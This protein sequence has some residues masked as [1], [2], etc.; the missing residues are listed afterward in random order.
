MAGLAHCH[1]Q[2]CCLRLGLRPLPLCRPAF[3]VPDLSLE[4]VM[5]QRL[6]PDAAAGLAAAGAVA[7]GLRG[8]VWPPGG[9]SP[10]R[11]VPLSVGHHQ[12]QSGPMASECCHQMTYP[13]HCLP[14]RPHPGRAEM[15]APLGGSCH[16][17]CR[18]WLPYLLA[19]A[20]LSVPKNHSP[21]DQNRPTRSKV[22]S[23]S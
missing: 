9:A 16:K 20:M 23:H 22:F 15:S 19:T 10:C 4:A 21:H 6:A 18:T 17:G 8:R 1:C 11:R 7:A 3:Q 12:D 14:S 2:S 13:R 5:Y